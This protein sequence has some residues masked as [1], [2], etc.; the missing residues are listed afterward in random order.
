FTAVGPRTTST[1]PYRE[2]AWGTGLAMRIRS[3]REALQAQRELERHELRA[4]L[5]DSGARAGNRVL[6]VSGYPFPDHVV[7]R[8]VRSLLAAGATVDVICPW[9]SNLVA[10]GRE[11]ASG[12]RA[13][14]LPV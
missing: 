5:A 1:A 7:L 14:R 13:F 3:Q 10:V 11:G 8:N 2:R 4:R 12:L 6:V 9:I